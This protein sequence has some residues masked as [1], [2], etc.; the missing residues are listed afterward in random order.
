MI[1]FSLGIIEILYPSSPRLKLFS[2]TINKIFDFLLIFD[3]NSNPVSLFTN[4]IKSFIKVSEALTP[5]YWIEV[6]LDNLKPVLESSKNMI[7]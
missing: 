5:S 7:L 6:F 4:E 1:K 2:F 3:F